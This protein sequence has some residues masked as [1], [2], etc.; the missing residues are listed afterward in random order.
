MERGPE[1]TPSPRKVKWS[2]EVDSEVS[3]DW[4]LCMSAVL[5]RQDGDRRVTRRDKRREGCIGLGEVSKE[6]SFQAAKKGQGCSFGHDF[7]A[8]SLVTR[9]PRNST[10]RRIH[11]DRHFK[12][13]PSGWTN[14]QWFQSHLRSIHYNAFNA[15]QMITSSTPLVVEPFQRHKKDPYRTHLYNLNLVRRKRD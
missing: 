12:M 11:V 9:D 4:C 6:E 13:D 5:G 1:E 3:S 15:M 8:S 2:S 7:R 14:L 10:T